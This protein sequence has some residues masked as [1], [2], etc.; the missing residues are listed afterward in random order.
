MEEII[1]SDQARKRRFSVSF[2]DLDDFKV[3]NDTVGHDAGDQLLVEV[4][5]RLR[6]T[7]DEDCF[8]ARFGGDEFAILMIEKADG[9]LDSR[10]A[11]EAVVEAIS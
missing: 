10:S 7:L 2:L 9:S 11:A 1:E 4:S 6:E 3:V 5:K 8:I